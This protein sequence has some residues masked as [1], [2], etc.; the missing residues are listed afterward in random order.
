MPKVM[1]LIEEVK[2]FRLNSKSSQQF[3][4]TPWLFRETTIAEEYILIPK[5]S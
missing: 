5:T 2:D 1:Q 3:A 4:S